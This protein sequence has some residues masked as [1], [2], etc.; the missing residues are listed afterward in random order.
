[1]SSIS[2]VAKGNGTYAIA[3]II[4]FYGVVFRGFGANDWNTGLIMISI[5]LI[6]ASLRSELSAHIV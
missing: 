1:M 6:G 5:A 4:I 3:G 2:W